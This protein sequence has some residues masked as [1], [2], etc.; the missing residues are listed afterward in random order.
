MIW[1]D[2]FQMVVILAGMFALII[3]G[4]KDVGGP[5][6]VWR[7]VIEGNRIDTNEFVTF[8]ILTSPDTL[9]D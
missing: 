3:E 1:T 4:T 9:L 8:L 5:A 6:E 7:R 2:A